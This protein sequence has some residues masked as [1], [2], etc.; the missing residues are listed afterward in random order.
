VTISRLRS[1]HTPTRSVGAHAEGDQAMGEP[2]GARIE[3]GVG[4]CRGVEL[5][6][7]GVR[8]AAHLLLEQRVHGEGRAD[9]AVGVVEGM[10]DL[11][12]LR[13]GQQRQAFC[14]VSPAS[15]TNACSKVSSCAP[16]RAIV[17]SS[18]RSVG[19]L[20]LAGDT[21]A[22]IAQRERQVELRG[23]ARDRDRRQRQAG[24]RELARGRV[25]PG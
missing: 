17:S 1:A 19:V 16:R 11:R 8:V 10:H 15:S 14:K 6:R 2:V 13:R 25:C 12:P 24:Q 21:A 3:L 4:Q 9:L 18:N 20:D 22:G 23:R 5:E 7:D